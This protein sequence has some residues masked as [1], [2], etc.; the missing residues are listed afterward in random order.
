MSGSWNKNLSANVISD[1]T[2]YLP[3]MLLQDSKTR[4]MND[5]LV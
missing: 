4:F 1:D 3:V 5:V 2:K